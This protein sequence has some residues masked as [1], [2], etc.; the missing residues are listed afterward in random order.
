[1]STKGLILGRQLGSF[2]YAAHAADFRDWFAAQTGAVDPVF[3][4]GPAHG[5]TTDDAVYSGACSLPN[6]DALCF[7]FDATTAD[8]VRAADLSI[9]HMGAHHGGSNQAYGGGALWTETT[10]ILS[11][12]AAT[13]VEYVDL[14]SGVCT[15]GPT[16]N[17]GSAGGFRG[18]CI[19]MANGR[20]VAVFAP[21]TATVIGLLWLDTLA[22]QNGPSLTNCRTAQTLSDGKVMFGRG[23]TGLPAVI[24]DVAAA[25][26]TTGTNPGG[27]WGTLL[28]PT[29][30]NQ[31]LFGP[32]NTSAVRTYSTEDAT[33]QRTS[34]GTVASADTLGVAFAPNGDVI[35][36]PFD[37]TSIPYYDPRTNLLV[38]GLS[39]TNA[40]GDAFGG[41]RPL[42]DGR[43]LFIPWKSPTFGVYTHLDATVG[44]YPYVAMAS[45][46]FGNAP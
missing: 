30:R 25:S 14:V 31:A 28:M 16:V 6:G 38:A 26:L 18:C 34:S 9:D 27:T 21:G 24:Y 40:A 41:A 32:S 43:M 8:I 5:Y 12:F 7:P 33:L 10:A 42:P 15:E 35:L 36:P 13:K 37:K 44:P 11:P 29:L 17:G 39:I 19:T 20:P 3:E 22:W 4:E 2:A 46:F 1:M 23:G 45:P